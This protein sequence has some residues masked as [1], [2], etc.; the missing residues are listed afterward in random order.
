MG[1]V[2]FG[3]GIDSAECRELRA[4]L[5]VRVQLYYDLDATLVFDT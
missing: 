2:V 3:S 5:R 4:T 1:M